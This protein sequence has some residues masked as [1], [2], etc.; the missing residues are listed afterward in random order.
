MLN[1]PENNIKF[2]DIQLETIEKYKSMVLNLETE[3]KIATTTLKGLKSD[4]EKTIKEFNYQNDL[5]EE[6]KAKVTPLE[7]KVIELESSIKEK[8]K[9]VSELNEYIS[10]KSA[11][12]EDSLVVSQRKNEELTIRE[13]TLLESENN[14]K[15]EKDE[16]VKEKIEHQARLA[17]FNKFIEEL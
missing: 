13:N 7:E 6:I 16:F 11:E 14:L 5:L 9:E 17:K 10:N 2:S 4:V 3:I 8:T 1:Q 12:I 15:K